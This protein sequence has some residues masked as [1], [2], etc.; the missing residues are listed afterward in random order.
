M[1]KEKEQL[2]AFSTRKV[3]LPQPHSGVPDSEGVWEPGRCS[4]DSCLSALR[5]LALPPP[6]WHRGFSAGRPAPFTDVSAMPAHPP[7]L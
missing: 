5:V 6:A 2:S 1:C 7:N 4:T 3:P